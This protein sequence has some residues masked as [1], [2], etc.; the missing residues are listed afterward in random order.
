MTMRRFAIFLPIFLLACT[1]AQKMDIEQL[2]LPPAFHIR[3][4]AQAG[5]QANDPRMMAFSPGGV[6]LASNPDDGKV[7]AFPDP[8]HT[9]QAERVA[10]V[11]GGLREPHGIAFHDGKLYV[12]ENH[13]IQRFDWDESQLRASNGKVI[14]QLPGGRGHSSRTILFANGKLYAS[15]GSTC[16]VCIEEDS[17]RAT[18]MEFNE[19]GSGMKIFARGLRNSVGLALNPKTKTIWATE[20]ERDMLGDNIP[21]DEIND[22]GVGGDFGWPYCYGRQ[23]PDRE[24]TKPGDER[25]AKTIPPKVELQA[26]SAPLGLAFYEGTMFPVGYRG[27]LF[28]ALHGSWNRSVPTGYKIV[29]VHINEKGEPAG[30][31]DFITGWIK[32]GETKKGVRMG[33]PVGIVFSSDGS[34]YLSDDEAGVIYRVTWER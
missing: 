5:A 27:D 22:L 7:Y 18:V 17:R 23:V 16:N 21:P 6:L 1:H 14:A 20:N 15:A 9:G 30:V 24:Y 32:P 33:R 26:H 2:H 3:I 12:A 4:F 8:K 13:Q 10:E 19:D 25:C 11:V 29:R 31:E 28:V 34:M